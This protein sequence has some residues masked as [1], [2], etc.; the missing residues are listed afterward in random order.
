MQTVCMGT[1][2]L[3]DAEK[4]LADLWIDLERNGEAT[5]RLSVDFNANGMVTLWRTCS[6]DG[7]GEGQLA[8]A[9]V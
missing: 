9:S 6:E 3:F 4:I 1:V 8:C 5:P 2:S 7:V